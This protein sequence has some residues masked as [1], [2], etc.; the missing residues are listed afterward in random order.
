V[1]RVGALAV[2][3]AFALASCATGVPTVDRL[4]VSNPTSYDLEV[5]VTDGDRDG[6]VLLGRILRGDKHTIEQIED[7]GP[8]WIFRFEYASD[9]LGGELRV[10]REELVGRDWTV[11]VPR[12][13]E[14]R[15][16]GEGI[17]PSPE[18]G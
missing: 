18:T 3:A 9:V 10:R 1:G 8:V 5:R 12:S 4:V 17:G 14:Q 6:W 15:L 7:L 11:E 13:V 16:R 2:A